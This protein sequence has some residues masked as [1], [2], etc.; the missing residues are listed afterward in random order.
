MIVVKGFSTGSVENQ[1][2]CYV[3]HGSLLVA[4]DTPRSHVFFNFE[5]DAQIFG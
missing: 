3:H 2:I 1:Q 5:D 4:M